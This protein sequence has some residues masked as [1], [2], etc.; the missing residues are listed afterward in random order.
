MA[1]EN[2]YR[3]NKDELHSIRSLTENTCT[4]IQMYHL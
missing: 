3:T 1:T 4:G 2:Q